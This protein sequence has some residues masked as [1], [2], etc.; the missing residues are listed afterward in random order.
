[1]YEVA[2]RVSRILRNH[3]FNRNLERHTRLPYRE[4]WYQQDPF[5]YI[6]SPSTTA[7]SIG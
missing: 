7:V 3:S 6:D 5:T 4:S 2:S 1:M